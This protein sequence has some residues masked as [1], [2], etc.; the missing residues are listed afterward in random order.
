MDPVQGA[1]DDVLL[2][3]V[4]RSGE[5]FHPIRPLSRPHRRPPR[6]I[7]HFVSHFGQGG[8]IGMVEVLGRVT[9]KVFVRDHCAMIAAPRPKRR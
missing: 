8:G 7:H 1:R 5:G 9:M 3:R 2:C 6:C 4:D